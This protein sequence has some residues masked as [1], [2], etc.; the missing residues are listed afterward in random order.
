[1]RILE[2]AKLVFVAGLGIGMAGV[3]ECRGAKGFEVPANTRI[4][5]AENDVLATQISSPG[6]G[7]TY[8]GVNADPR[9]PLE[10]HD[11]FGDDSDVSFDAR[12]NDS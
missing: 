5:T 10:I 11:G 1:M 4:R 8:P 3:S 2:F 6:V 7:I 12:W 9:P